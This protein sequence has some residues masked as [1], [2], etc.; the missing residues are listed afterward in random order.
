MRNTCPLQINLDSICAQCG[1]RT[2]VHL[3][4]YRRLRPL[5]ELCVSL[6]LRV[7]GGQGPSRLRPYPQWKGA[8]RIIRSLDPGIPVRGSWVEISV[9]RK[10][11]PGGV[12]VYKGVRIAHPLNT[13]KVNLSS[14]NSY[15]GNSHTFSPQEKYLTYECAA[16]AW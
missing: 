1:I 5:E 10:L 12:G 2:H 3:S 7:R 13:T 6:Y 9:N 8:L 15:S 16:K 4:N 14:F 11:L